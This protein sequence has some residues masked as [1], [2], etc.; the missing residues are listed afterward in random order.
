MRVVLQHQPI[1]ESCKCQHPQHE[2]TSIWHLLLMASWG[3]CRRSW[4]LCTGRNCS[5]AIKCVDAV[6]TSRYCRMQDHC[7][8]HP[9]KARWNYHSRSVVVCKAC[10]RHPRT[11]GWWC[12]GCCSHG[13]GHRD[14]PQGMPSQY[15]GGVRILLSCTHCSCMDFSCIHCICIHCNYMCSQ[16]HRLHALCMLYAHFAYKCLLSKGH[17]VYN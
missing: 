5:A 12:T 3:C 10:W 13:V 9:S 15:M 11:E 16:V 14:L 8:C 7:A 6:S 2:N 17:A 1:L 4:N